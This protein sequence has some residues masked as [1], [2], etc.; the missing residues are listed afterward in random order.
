MQCSVLYHAK[1]RKHL[2]NCSHSPHDRS[3]S[4]KRGCCDNQKQGSKTG[5]R[6]ASEQ[7]SNLAFRVERIEGFLEQ[8]ATH[9]GL[10][11]QI[12]VDAES[13]PGGD[14][15]RPG[16][17]LGPHHNGALLK[18][19]M[20]FGRRRDNDEVSLLASNEGIPDPP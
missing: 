4:D 2:W 9:M 19:S 10:S 6:Y 5:E 7:V 3:R 11:S 14:P 12:F 8:I 17:T 13:G 1:S 16:P 18:R 15:Q 20:D